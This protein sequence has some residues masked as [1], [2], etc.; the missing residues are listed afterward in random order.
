ML[1]GVPSKKDQHESRSYFKQE[2]IHL[3]SSNWDVPQRTDVVAYE[4]VRILRRSVQFVGVVVKNFRRT[5]KHKKKGKK[6]KG[7]G[8]VSQSYPPGLGATE[9][10]TV[11]DAPGESRSTPVQ[12]TTCPATALPERW[13]SARGKKQTTIRRCTCP[14]N[15]EPRILGRSF[16]VSASVAKPPHSPAT[17]KR[18]TAVG[19]NAGY[20]IARC[21]IAS[22]VRESTVTK[23][24]NQGVV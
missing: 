23:E 19:D 2:S 20:R 22:V 14:R 9:T 1:T 17:L 16:T 3:Q 12:R 4:S 6:I 7:D 21:E 10:K 13:K 15:S 18:G 8:W 11:T 24:R 5:K